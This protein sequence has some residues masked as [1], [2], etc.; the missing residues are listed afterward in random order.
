MAD[1]TRQDSTRLSDRLAIGS[2][3]FGGLLVA[4]VLVARAMSSSGQSPSRTDLV[5]IAATRQ[6]TR[7]VVGDQTNDQVSGPVATSPAAPGIS[8]T[9]RAH[10]AYTDGQGVVLRASPHEDDRT[11]RGFMDGD[12]V[13][14]LERQGSDWVRIRGDNGEDGWVPARYLGP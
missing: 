11:P 7:V 3:L 13:T 2:A 5:G 10:I 12:S 4:A 14:V 1:R 6:P 9:A 8:A